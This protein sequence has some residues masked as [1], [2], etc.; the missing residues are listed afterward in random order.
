MKPI[1]QYVCFISLIIVPTSLCRNIFSHYHASPT[2]GHMGEY[3]T[4]F[5]L[6]LRFFFTGL[7]KDVKEW[8]KVFAHWVAHNVWLS[9]KIELYFSCPVTMPFYIMHVNIWSPGHLLDTN[10][11]TIQLMKSMCDLTQFVISSVVQNINAEIIAKTFMEE[12][13]L[14]FGMKAVIVVDADSKFRSV[15]EDMCKSLK[16]HLWPLARGNHKLISV[17]KSHQ[18]INNNKKQSWVII[19]ELIYL[20]LKMPKLPNI[21]GIPY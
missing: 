14:S 2:G 19:E 5:H 17:E 7:R 10:K 12:V 21:I 20:S 9:Q 6:C 16:I 1:F 13:D 11:D 3:K 15:F 4:L 18:F 8:V